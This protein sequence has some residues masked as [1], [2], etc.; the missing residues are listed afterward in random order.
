MPVIKDPTYKAALSA[1]Q[2]SVE[3]EIT[4]VLHQKERAIQD[5]R[6]QEQLNIQRERLEEQKR[7]ASFP[8][9]RQV[10]KEE[11]LGTKLNE[12]ETEINEAAGS[13]KDYIESFDVYKKG[14]ENGNIITGAYGEDRLNTHKTLQALAENTGVYSKD[15]MENA[16][17]RSQLSDDLKSGAIQQVFSQLKGHLGAG[18]SDA[19]RKAIQ[20]MG[21]SLDRDANSNLDSIET[22]Q[23]AQQRNIEAAKFME[24]YK[25]NKS[26]IPGE[27]DGNFQAAFTKWRNEQPSILPDRLKAMIS[28]NKEI[29][30]E[31]YNG[32]IIT[33]EKGNKMRL[34][35]DKKSW[36]KF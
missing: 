20:L 30:S 21:I 12:L 4:R 18:I 14:I 16:K 27:L 34:S 15:W 7:Q 6:Y 11:K 5:A 10:Q 3:A 1:K 29:E 2:R 23:K 32:P 35:D 25:Q 24:D 36:V 8:Y 19:D 13:A 22:F 33:D 28:K 26:S 17:L 9:K 31:K